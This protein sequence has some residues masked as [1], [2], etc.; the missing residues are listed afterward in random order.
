[1]EWTPLEKPVKKAKMSEDDL[2]MAVMEW[3]KLQDQADAM[4]E[5]IKEAVLERGENLSVGSVTAKI[6]KGRGKYDHET[7]A[8]ENVSD[9][10]PYTTVEVIETTTIDFQKACKDAKVHP[11]PGR[12]NRQIGDCEG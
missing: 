12:S 7:A 11:T 10:S 6:S 2:V 8:R 4:A 9:L 3:K 1:M 5:I